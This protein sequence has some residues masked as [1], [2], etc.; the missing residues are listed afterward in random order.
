MR[1]KTAA[2]LFGVLVIIGIGSGCISFR[3]DPPPEPEREIREITLC[4][5]INEAQELLQPGEGTTEFRA[6]RDTV[7]CFIYLAEVA[8]ALTLQWRWY[9]PDRVLFR[10]SQDVQINQD[11]TYL[12][13]VTAYDKISPE[14]L[15]GHLGEWSVA[16]FVNGAL[17]GRHSFVVRKET[18]Q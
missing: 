18:R 2:S 17:L 4:A 12:E 14:P 3:I 10:E 15:E 6:G 13:A 7:F 5:E 11:E 9:T 16:V 1:H 8:E